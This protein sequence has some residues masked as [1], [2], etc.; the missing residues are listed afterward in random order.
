MHLITLETNIATDI[1]TCFDAARSIELHLE[2]TAQTQE[3]VVS[4]KKFG[5]CELGEFITWEGRHFGIRQ[6]FTS[7]ITKMEMPYF[8]EDKM[9]KGAFKSFRHEHY[10][11]ENTNAVNMTD[12]LFY[13]VPLGVFGKIFDG[14]VL[15]KYLISLLQKRN[16]VIQYY[17][18]NKINSK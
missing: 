5:L 17:C 10:F 15:R 1:K 14:L 7:E 6:Q 9:R 16:K 11:E 12:H 18:E 13:E 4:N 8:F 3:K 2:S